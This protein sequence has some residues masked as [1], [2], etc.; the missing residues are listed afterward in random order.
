MPGDLRIS[1]SLQA[2]VEEGLCVSFWLKWH[3]LIGLSIWFS[4][5][6]AL[7]L[8]SARSSTTYVYSCT[9]PSRICSSLIGDACQFNRFV[10]MLPPSSWLEEVY[11]YGAG[12]H[13]H[14]R[15]MDSGHKRVHDF[16]FQAVMTPDGII[17]H[18]GDPVV[19]S[20][21][22][23]FT[24]RRLEEVILR[25]WEQA[26]LSQ[27][28]W[29]FLY[30]DPPNTTDS[31]V[32]MGTFRKPPGAPRLSPEQELFNQ[33]QSKLC[34]RVEHG[35]GLVQKEW[36]KRG[37]PKTLRS[38]QSSIATYFFCAVFLSNMWTIVKR[39][40]GNQVSE[41]FRTL[42]IEPLTIEEY[43]AGTDEAENMA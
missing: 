26:H 10:N 29:L 3:G 1:Q 9:S 8:R 35:F 6:V 39:G 22:D 19:G 34:V 4:G 31:N 43:F 16:K 15:P 28:N 13:D 21:G 24:T 14:Q 11:E 2:F 7:L 41:R 42:G 33:E 12:T 23:S 25:H 27:E 30:G 32:T 5:L 20:R 37:F 17:S 36:M 40:D 38:G 18:L